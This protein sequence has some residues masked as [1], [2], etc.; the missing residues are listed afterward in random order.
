MEVIWEA[1]AIWEAKAIWEAWQ[2]GRLCLNFKEATGDLGANGLTLASHRQV[3]P[4][5]VKSKCGMWL[6]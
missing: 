1:L 3:K 6:D 5:K 2:F 4:T